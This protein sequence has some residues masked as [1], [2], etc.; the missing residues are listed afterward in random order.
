MDYVWVSSRSRSMSQNRAQNS[1]RHFEL[2]QT[3]SAFG[4]P[5]KFPKC[6]NGTAMQSHRPCWTSTK[7]KVTTFLD[8]SSL[9]TKPGLDHTNHTWNANQMNGRVPVLLV[10]IKYAANLQNVGYPIKFSKCNN[11]TTMQSHRPCWTGTK[12]KVTT[13]LDESSLWT[14]PGLA[15]MNQICHLESI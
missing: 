4:Y 12:G 13:F 5:M 2:P 3:C 6:N 1:A 8:E 14:K 9:W 7:G 15:L 11:G 10:Q